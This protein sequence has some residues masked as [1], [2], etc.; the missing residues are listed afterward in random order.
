MKSSTEVERG[1]PVEP[2]CDTL[3]TEKK[4]IFFQDS[5]ENKDTRSETLDGYPES[6]YTGKKKKG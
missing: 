1:H 4:R 6:H 5:K 3:K 2:S